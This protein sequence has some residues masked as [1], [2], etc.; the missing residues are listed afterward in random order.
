MEQHCFWAV[1]LNT[2]KT[3]TVK[4]LKLNIPVWFTAN[5][6]GGADFSRKL[7]EC[8]AIDYELLFDIINKDSKQY[9]M[10]R[11][12]VKPSH[13]MLFVGVHCENGKP[14]RWKVQ[15]S[16]GK[17]TAFLSMSEKWFDSN[18]FEIAV[19]MDISH[20][21]LDKVPIQLEPWDILSTV[22]F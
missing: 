17:K 8:N 7:M 15:N 4:C 9:L 3:L 11:R 5:I 18:V 22:A 12:T 10:E 2:L 1:D 19:P 6:G 21:D 16:W 14:I 20:I 13:A